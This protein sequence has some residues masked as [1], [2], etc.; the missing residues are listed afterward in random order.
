MRR[1]NPGV[2]EPLVYLVQKPQSFRVVGLGGL[3]L[4]SV[5]M[6]SEA[7]GHGAGYGLLGL[8][9]LGALW[10]ET[11]LTACR[12]CRH[13]GTMHCLGQGMLVSKIFPRVATGA[14]DFQYQAHLAM[15]G[16]YLLY[17]LFWLWHVPALGFIFTLWVPLLLI[18]ADAPNGFSWRARRA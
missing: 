5:L 8:L 3:A 17:G 18:S 4:F 2:F 14:S 15:L 16:I 7:F 9:L 12:R 11:S 6:L 1:I 13:Y 10:L